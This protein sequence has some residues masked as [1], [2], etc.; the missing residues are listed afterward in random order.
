MR[1]AVE[2]SLLSMKLGGVGFEDETQKERF[3]EI[4]LKLAEL[5]TKYSNNVLDA[6]KAFSVVVTDKKEMEGV[7]SSAKGMWAS[8]YVASLDEGEGEEPNPEE[9]P[10][11]IGLDGP[12][13]IAALSHLKSSALREKVYL[14]YTTRASELTDGGDK[15]NIPLIQEILS[16]KQEQAKLL[17]F[18]SFADLSLARKMAPSVQ[19]VLELSD[20]IAEKALPA[21]KK[22]LDEVTSYAIENGFEFAEGEDKM[23]PWDVTFWSERLK[24]SKFDL[25]EE[26]L[27][28]YFAL[29]AVLDGMFGLVERIF[30]IEVK[31]AEEG[32]AEVWH[33][34]VKFFNVFDAE[35][36]EQI[37]SFYLDPYSRPADKRGGAWMDTC[38]GKLEDY[39]KE[40]C[41]AYLVC[42]GSL[43]FV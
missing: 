8:S 27:R 18:D 13:Y 21:A 1:R 30:G 37:A 2:Q 23:K 39:E 38:I 29:P 35:S 40:I 17:G 5:S 26:E 36:K 32:D 12:S 10:W 28:P 43:V 9:G 3:N 7:P 11:R 42:N 24:E 33:P 41:V 22:E 16:L 20:L 25:T 4:R 6:T 19:S 14:G 15:N 34:D 31:Q